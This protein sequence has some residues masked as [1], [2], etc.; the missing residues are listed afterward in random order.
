MERKN[1]L[2]TGSLSQGSKHDYSFT[3]LGTFHRGSTVSES[4]HGPEQKQ[5]PQ[6]AEPPC[7]GLRLVLCVVWGPLCNHRWSDTSHCGRNYLPGNCTPLAKRRDA[8]VL[9]PHWL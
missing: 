3:H 8:L 4:R 2:G 6:V 9:C 1:I 5:E 7:A